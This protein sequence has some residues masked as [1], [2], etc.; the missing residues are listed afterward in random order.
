MTKLKALSVR[1]PFA[2]QIA[3]GAKRIE[4][5]SWGVRVSGPVA[6]HRCGKNGAIIGVMDIERVISA[7][8]ALREMPEQAQFISGPLCWVIKSFEPCAPISCGGR[9]SL[10]DCALSHKNAPPQQECTK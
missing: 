5:R 6:L 3:S 2:S 4:N 1:D 10:W 9:L 7:E 8:Q